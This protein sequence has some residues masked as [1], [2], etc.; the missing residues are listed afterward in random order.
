MLQFGKYV[1]AASVQEAYDLL[2]RGRSTRVIG[3][4]VWLRLQDRRI[5]TVIDISDCGL[6]HIERID[7]ESGDPAGVEAAGAAA[8]GAAPGKLPGN[9]WS[10]G[11]MVSLH[12]LETHTAFNASTCGVFEAAVRDIVGVQMRNLATVGG[13]LYGRFGFSDVLTALLPLDCEVELAG[14]GRMPIAEFAEAGYMHDILVRLIVRDRDYRASF[15]CLRR[16]ATDF[17]VLNVCAARWD[18][19]WRVAVGARPTRARL[20]ALDALALPAEFTEAELG[21]ACERLAQLPMG[22]NMRGSERYRRHLARELGRRALLEAAGAHTEGDAPR[23]EAASLRT[24]A[25]AHAEGDD[26]RCS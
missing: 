21:A 23:A 26:A 10:I 7:F 9:A 11:A 20:V 15:Q 4:G 17:P 19:S 12:A 13:S 16:S 1:R 25:A 8:A 24:T 3:G 18:G 14:A 22:T 2:K 5:A 6:D